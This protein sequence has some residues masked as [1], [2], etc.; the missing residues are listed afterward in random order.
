LRDLRIAC[1]R[2]SLPVEVPIVLVPLKLD[3][4]KK[5]RHRAVKAQAWACKT[6]AAVQSKPD[7]FPLR[8]AWTVPDEVDG[9]GFGRREAIRCRCSGSAANVGFSAEMALSRIVDDAVDNT[10]FGIAGGYGGGLG[11]G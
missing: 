9:L 7:L 5:E 4:P 6:G 8:V 11:L 10:I 3:D 2:D 1:Q